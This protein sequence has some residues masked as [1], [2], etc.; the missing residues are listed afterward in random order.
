MQTD[1]WLTQPAQPAQCPLCSKPLKASSK[2]CYACGFS[3][4][5]PRSTGSSV[6]IDPAIYTYQPPES[7]ST[8]AES[9]EHAK[10]LSNPPKPVKP[11][12]SVV[13]EG[14][15]QEQTRPRTGSTSIPSPGKHTAPVSKS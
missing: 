6:W 11:T 9:P 13:W 3:L 14:N 15:G 2:T 8:S 1:I 12:G 10:G 5:S 4:E 7:A